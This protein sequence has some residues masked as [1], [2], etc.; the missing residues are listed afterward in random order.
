MRLKHLRFNSCWETVRCFNAPKPL[1]VLSLELQSNIQMTLFVER[2]FG[3]ISSRWTSCLPGR[4][5]GIT[6]GSGESGLKRRNYTGLRWFSVA[7]SGGERE[8]LDEG[9]ALVWSVKT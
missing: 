8:K 2:H 9:Y 1:R 7:T 5:G 3:D 4:E 6:S